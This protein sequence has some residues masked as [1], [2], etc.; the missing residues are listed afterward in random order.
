VKQW[1]HSSIASENANLHNHFGN[2]FVSFSENSTGNSSTSRP[3]YTTP[4]MPNYTAGTL[5]MNI[6][7]FIVALQASKFIVARNWKQHRCPSAEEWI[8]KMWYIYTVEY[9]SAIK[10]KDMNFSSKW[11]K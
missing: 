5:A 6:A 2:Q 9:C 7:M 10:N 11:M 4:A 3:S 1:E 8:K